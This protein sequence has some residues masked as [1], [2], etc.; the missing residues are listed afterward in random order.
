M[1]TD[2]AGPTD[3]F[4]N[5]VIVRAGNPEENVDP[6]YS[7]NEDTAVVVIPCTPIEEVSFWYA[8]DFLFINE[9]ITFTLVITPAE[10]SQPFT[11]TWDMDDVYGWVTNGTEIY[12]NYT[13]GGYKDV[14]VTLK[15]ACSSG[16]YYQ[17]QIWV[18]VSRLFLPIIMR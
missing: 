4:T 17:E 16:I 2:T 11:A 12:H 5:T 15:N 8:P 18:A 6:D 1:I 10:A 13:T 3:V 9:W 7:N 14:S